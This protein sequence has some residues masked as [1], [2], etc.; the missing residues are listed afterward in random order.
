M[1]TEAFQ[2]TQQKI[3][4]SVVAAA[5]DG[6]TTVRQNTVEFRS[7]FVQMWQFQ[8]LLSHSPFWSITPW[9][10]GCVWALVASNPWSERTVCLAARGSVAPGDR[11]HPEATSLYCPKPAQ[12]QSAS[13]AR[14]CS[15]RS[16]PVCRRACADTLCSSPAPP[17]APSPAL[18]FPESRK[19]ETRAGRHHV[20][21]LTAV[22]KVNTSTCQNTSVP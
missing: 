9:W 21:N 2:K 7:L 19:A 20:T 1:K 17:A 8:F 18:M 6:D 5:V 15:R 16:A 22:L 12:G 4:Q 13:T 3:W 14:G 10:P 11:N